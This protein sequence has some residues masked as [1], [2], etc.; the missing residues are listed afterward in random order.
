MSET[1]ESR[2]AVKVELFQPDYPRTREFSSEDLEEAELLEGLPKFVEEFDLS[3]LR[4]GASYL[5]R[6][7][8][9][10][11]KEATRGTIICEGLKCLYLRKAD[12]EGRVERVLQERGI[13]A[14]WM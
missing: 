2:A 4:V 3:T 14:V 9:S 1:G 6:M 11:T 13:S 10:E 8:G 12:R 5:L 7:F